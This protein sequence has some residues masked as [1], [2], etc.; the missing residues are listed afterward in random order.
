MLS[1]P[2]PMVPLLGP[3]LPPVASPG[4]SLPPALG[5]LDAG[6]PPQGWLHPGFSWD[7]NMLASN[8]NMMTLQPPPTHEW[9]MDTGAETHMTSN[10]VNLCTFQ[11]PSFFTPSNIVVGTGSLLPVTHTGSVTFPAACG[12]LHLNNVIVSPHL[13]KNLI[14]VRQFTIDNKCSVEFDPSGFSVKG[15]ETRNV[16]I[17]CNSSGPLY[18]LLSS[19]FRPLALA[20]GISSSTLWHLRLGH[21]GHE[22]LSSLVSSCAITCNKSDSDHLCH[23]CQLG[24][25]VRLLFPTSSSRATNN[26]D[27]IHCDLWTSPVPS[28]SGYKYYLVILDDCSHFLWTSPLCLKSDT[29]STLTHFL[30]MSPLSLASPLKASSAIMVVSLITPPPAHSLLHMMS[31]SACLVPI[32]CH[33]MERLSELFAPPT[34]SF[35]RSYSKPACPRPTGSR[36]FILPHIFSIAI[37]LKPWPPPHPSWHYSKHNPPMTMFVSLDVVVILISPSLL[38]TS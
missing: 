22:A 36:P 31:F 7:S 3:F 33:K 1:G 24:H 14:F 12:P 13:I 4:S 34:I 26:F 18:S 29:F 35:A 15:L 19:V 21:L 8:F 23:A 9:Y 32:P 6:P 37:S 27:L 17:R 10:S 16:I 11:T 28:I 25:H 5:F 20:A 2:P 38:H 30:P